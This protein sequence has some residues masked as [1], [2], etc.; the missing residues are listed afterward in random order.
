MYVSLAAFRPAQHLTENLVYL[1]I[2]K[3]RQRI[4]WVSFDFMLL[5]VP[6]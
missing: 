5:L 6:L 2:V 3:V 1:N 4:A